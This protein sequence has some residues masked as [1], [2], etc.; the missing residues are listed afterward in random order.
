MNKEQL[1]YILK[2]QNSIHYFRSI[3]SKMLQLLPHLQRTMRYAK[4]KWRAF[5]YQTW[6]NL[7]LTSSNFWVSVIRVISLPY[8]FSPMS[9]SSHGAHIRSLVPSFEFLSRIFTLCRRRGREYIMQSLI[10]RPRAGRFTLAER[11]KRVYADEQMERLGVYFTVYSNIPRH[12]V[13]CLNLIDE[14]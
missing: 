4:Q 7:Y 12:T 2:A 5:H 8:I 6:R 1:F 13:I 11:R 9:D 3:C 14:R 10:Y